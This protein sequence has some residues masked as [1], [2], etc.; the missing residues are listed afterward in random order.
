MKEL[1]KYKTFLTLIFSIL[2]VFILLYNSF[3]KEA[4]IFWFLVTILALLF[5][6]TVAWLIYLLIV[7]ILLFPTG[8]DFQESRLLSIYGFPITTEKLLIIISPVV[9]L[10]QYFEKIPSLLKKSFKYTKY[11]IVRNPTF[12]LM[13]FFVL[14]SLISIMISPVEVQKLRIALFTLGFVLFFVTSIGINKKKDIK[15][16]LYVLSVMIISVS[17]YG[18]YEFTVEKNIFENSTGFQPFSTGDIYR[19]KS[20]QGLPL[21]LSSLVNMIFPL[22]LVMAI[23]FRKSYIKYFFISGLVVLILAQVESF[24]R[25]GWVVMILEIIA[26]TILFRKKIIDLAVGVVKDIPRVILIGAVFI[27]TLFIYITSVSL[28]TFVDFRVTTDDAQV[29]SISKKTGETKE[30]NYG[31]T[32][33]TSLVSRIQA[34]ELS[35]RVIVDRPLLGVGMG[36]FSGAVKLYGQDL[37]VLKK[38]SAADNSYTMLLTETGILGL[39][40]FLGIIFTVLKKSF[41]VYFLAKENFF[42]DVAL[43]ILITQFGAILQAVGFELYSYAHSIFIFWILSGFIF[44]YYRIELTKEPKS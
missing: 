17:L 30:F 7:N 25:T 36:G 18:L 31:R 22:V 9:L 32:N 33:V 24:T 3:Y 14:L 40:V 42:K 37:E 13:G 34:L 29:S 12:S 41:D 10:Y 21:V 11:L 38:F 39:L 6:K 23:Y 20:V 26:L 15:V 1:S 5:K 8:G 35:R 19:I 4:A 16:A 2:I 28:I 27:L 44:A 43:A